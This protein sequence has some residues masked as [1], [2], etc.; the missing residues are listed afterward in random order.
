[1]YVGNVKFSKRD[2]QGFLFISLCLFISLHFSSFL[3]VSLHVSLH[4]SL[5]V[6]IN[7]SLNMSLHVSTHLILKRTHLLD[8]SWPCFK[9]RKRFSQ[10]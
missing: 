8:I 10:N 6:S 2:F 3:F 4:A 9:N 1:M 7:V 5:N